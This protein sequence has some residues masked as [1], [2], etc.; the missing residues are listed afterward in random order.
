[1]SSHPEKDPGTDSL[2]EEQQGTAHAQMPTHGASE[3][4]I[5]YAQR[6]LNLHLCQREGGRT[7]NLAARASGCENSSLA[8]VS[9]SLAAP[10][11]CGRCGR[12]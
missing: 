9:S 8:E 4:Y 3:S 6:P 10:S 12:R 1:M 2:E 11:V 5:A 7:A